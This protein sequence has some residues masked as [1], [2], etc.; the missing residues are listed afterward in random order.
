MSPRRFDPPPGSTYVRFPDAA[1]TRGWNDCLLSVMKALNLRVYGTG[2]D[3]D[4]LVLLNR[5]TRQLIGLGDKRAFRFSI[6]MPS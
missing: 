1:Y 3:L 4:D 6:R 5:S 2:C